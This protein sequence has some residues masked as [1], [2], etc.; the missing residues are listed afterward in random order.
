[1]TNKNKAIE[2]YSASSIK[3]LSQRTHL[4][5]RMSLTFGDE[6]GDATN[7]FSSQ[8]SVAIREIVDN[9][10][11]EVLAGHADKVSV[12]FHKNGAISVQD[13]GR[14]IPVDI[15]LDGEGRPASAIYLSLAVTMSGGKFGSDSNRFSGGLNG[16]GASSTNFV[17]SRFDV[18]VYRDNKIHSLSF[19]DGRPGFFAHDDD[20]NAPFEE[21]KDLSIIKVEK[22]TRSASDKE[23]FKTGTLV[24]LWLDDSSF[25][26]KYPVNRLDITERLRGTAFLI[27]SINIDVINEVDLIETP[28]GEMIPRQEHFHFENGIEELVTLNQSQSPICKVIHLAGEGSYL[29]NVG[30]LQEDGVNVK[31]QDVKRHAPFEIVLSYD[32]SYEYNVESYVNTIRT[33]NGG[34]HE[35]ALEKSLTKVFNEKLSSMRGV[36]PKDLELPIFDDYKEGLSAVISVKVSEPQFTGQSKEK[37]GGREV[38]KAFTKA[39]T[40]VL[41]EYVQNPKNIDTLK[42]IGQ[43]VGEAAKARQS[44]KE[45]RDLVRAKNAL[46]SNRDMPV[47]LIDCKIT[48]EDYSELYI[49]EGDSAKGS[50]KAARSSFNQAILPIR[51]KIINVSKTNMKKI[52]ENKEVQDIVKCLDAGVG[53]DFDTDKLRYGRI[54]IAADADPDG[55]AISC[56]ILVLFWE[57]FRPVVEE[58]RLYQIQTPLF[59]IKE[60]GSDVRHYAQTEQERVDIVRSLTK[61]KKR[62]TINRIKGLGEAPKE[63][64]NE[65]AMNPETRIVKRVTAKDVDEAQR[66]LDIALGEDVIPRKEW[67]EAHPLDLVDAE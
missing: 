39:M 6:T 52:L 13:N 26:S 29:E 54:F 49:A 44:K 42:I 7:K 51:G 37:L 23:L 58:G 28:E 35:E 55:G 56:L 30:V 66:Y 50:L 12:K 1:M 38:L 59:V 47:K 65:T 34:I 11:D 33:K 32:S 31:Y 15:G 25:A 27:P 45:E 63:V 48:H 57:L 36:F 19:K 16:V 43:K 61:R 62:F 53:K 18:T 40:D 8:K 14:G 3:T 2:E 60:N 17:S 9:S 10:V 21:L 22:D 5:K 46:D 67:I 64:L 41:T 20:P 24:K 4:L